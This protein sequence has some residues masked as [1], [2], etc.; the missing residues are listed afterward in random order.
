GDSPGWQAGAA[1][2]PL[3]NGRPSPPCHYT[4]RTLPVR[5][6]P[7]VGGVFLGRRWSVLRADAAPPSGRPPWGRRET[8][9]GWPL[10][11]RR[12]PHR[13]LPPASALRSLIPRPDRRGGF[14]A[15]CSPSRS[16]AGRISKRRISAERVAHVLLRG[17]RFSFDQPRARGKVGA[18]P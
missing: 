14:R 7:P 1:P 8:R 9:G 12:N 10:R 17:R 13:F 18:T 16:L 2:Y 15:A 5:S 6:Q 11:G 4:G 3:R